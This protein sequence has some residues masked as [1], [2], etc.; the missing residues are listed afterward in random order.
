MI[1]NHKDRFKKYND[2]RVGLELAGLDWA[3][4]EPAP[5]MNHKNFVDIH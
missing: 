4:L 3:G 1:K 2:V 5:T